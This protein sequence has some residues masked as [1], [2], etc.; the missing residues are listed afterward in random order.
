MTSN[1]ESTGF[2][3]VNSPPL[4]I[5]EYSVC[6]GA[7]NV[8]ITSDPR[9]EVQEITTAMNLEVDGLATVGVGGVLLKNVFNWQQVSPQS[10][11]H[12]FCAALLFDC[13]G[14]KTGE[15]PRAR[16]AE[17]GGLFLFDMCP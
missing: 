5:T 9:P 11:M 15:E 4:F 2:L 14:V 13:G 17:G 7:R 1:T 6:V 12:I 10:Q 16:D 3:R 8:K